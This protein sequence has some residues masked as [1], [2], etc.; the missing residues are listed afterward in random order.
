MSPGCGHVCVCVLRCQMDGGM[1]HYFMF[2]CALSR[3]GECVCECVC[4]RNG[5]AQREINSAKL[6]G[7]R[8]KMREQAGCRWAAHTH[9]CKPPACDAHTLICH[10]PL[11]V[12]S[13]CVFV[14]LRVCFRVCAR[15]HSRGECIHTHT[16]AATL[17][18]AVKHTHTRDSEWWFWDE[19]PP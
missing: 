11:I 19:G 8:L 9:T 16:Q 1:R 18:Y 14:W 5:C 7:L 2:D 13:V 12:C 6:I 4:A 3:G 15:M 17:R 10:T